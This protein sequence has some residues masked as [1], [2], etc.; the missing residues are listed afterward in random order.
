MSSPLLA[1]ALP[2]SYKILNCVLRWIAGQFHIPDSKG[3]HECNCVLITPEDFT[4]C[5]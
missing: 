4:P 5:H 3:T 2:L 1:P